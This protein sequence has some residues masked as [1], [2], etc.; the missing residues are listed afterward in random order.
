[1]PL[2]KARK[3]KKFRV[4]FVDDEK[5]VH[6][7][8]KKIAEKMRIK[9]RF[10]FDPKQA[11][12]IIAQRRKAI[13]K[14]IAKKTMLLQGAEPKQKRVLG[15]QLRFLGQ[16]QKNPFDL[17]VSDINMPRGE[18]TGIGFILEL[19]K[20]IPYQR[21]L[22]HSDDVENMEELDDAHGISNSP[23]LYVSGY[24]NDEMLKRRMHEQLPKRK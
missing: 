16:M 20:E 23:K 11:K 7:Y 18:P 5:G 1:M 22:V 3:P 6:N 9:P 24:M 21:V 8:E 14:L 12:K 19:K 2:P 13:E 17:V 4:L 10:A 15:R